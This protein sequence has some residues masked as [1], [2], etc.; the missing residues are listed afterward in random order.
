[1][2]D[3]FRTYKKLK[4][5]RGKKRTIE[6]DTLASEE[7]NSEYRTLFIEESE[8][9]LHVIFSK[10]FICFRLSMI[11]LLAIII[12]IPP[13]L[14]FFSIISGLLSLFFLY[15]SQSLKIKFTKTARDYTMTVNILNKYMENMFGIIR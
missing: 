8:K 10:Q 6:L 5:F 3:F 9:D 11:F 13:K 14:I 2:N 1:M 7:R 15:L 4:L 12:L